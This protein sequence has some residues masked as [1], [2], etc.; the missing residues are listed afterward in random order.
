MTSI[1]YDSL[2]ERLLLIWKQIH[3]RIHK[4]KSAS[5]F[6]QAYELFSPTLVTKIINNLK[7]ETK[8]VEDWVNDWLLNNKDFL[9]YSHLLVSE[10]CHYISLKSILSDL[11]QNSCTNIEADSEISD[12][13]LE[14]IVYSNSSD[15]DLSQI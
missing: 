4:S 11:S 14:K 5:K 3:A 2:N 8:S 12:D 10:I 6:Y 13:V 9:H 7:E 1:D 15:R